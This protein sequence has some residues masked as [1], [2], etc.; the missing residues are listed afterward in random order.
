MLVLIGYFDESGTHRDAEATAV[1]GYVSTAEQWALFESDWSKA[2]EEYSIDHFHMTDF[3]NRVP[4]YRSWTDQERRYRLARLIKIINTHALASVGVVVPTR[5]FDADFSQETKKFVG[6]LYGLA[7]AMCF[8]ETASLVDEKYPSAKIAHVFEQGCSSGGA[9]LRNY[10]W[11]SKFPQN[12]KDLKLLSLKFEN[13]RNFV[14]L[15]AADILAYELYK[16]LPKH[17]GIDNQPARTQNL[18]MLKECADTSWITI[19]EA[20][21]KK[22]S[23]F[24]AIGEEYHQEVDRQKSSKKKRKR[25]NKQLGS[26]SDSHPN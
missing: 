1:A 14:P 3:A 2:L 18:L 19:D 26:S 23:R 15:Q 5:P 11:N 10:L 24:A 21:M 4:P 25:K 22:H 20:E 9:V 16:Q 13:K 8:V 17:I 7:C 12:K 6:G